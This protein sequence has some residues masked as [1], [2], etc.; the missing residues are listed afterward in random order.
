MNLASA[1]AESAQKHAEKIA[2]FWGEKEYS[3]AQLWGQSEVVSSELRQ[4][5]QV[6]AGDRVGLWLKNCPEFIPA[7]FG[8]FD[9]LFY[10]AYQS[11]L[12][13]LLPQESLAPGNALMQATRVGSKP[14]VFV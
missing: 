6:K 9:A 10:P 2:L 14:D 7:L 1:F 3:Y 4:K 13:R 11:I 5:F 12:P 8:T